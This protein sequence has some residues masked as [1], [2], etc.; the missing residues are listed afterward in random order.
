MPKLRSTPSEVL[1]LSERDEALLASLA[2]HQFLTFSQ[3][4]RLHFHARSETPARRALWRLADQGLAGNV[5]E[6]TPYGRQTVWY[7]TAAGEVASGLRLPGTRRRRTAHLGLG[8]LAHTLSVNEFCIGLVEE[9]RQRRDHFSWSSW[10]NEVAH[11]IPKQGLLIPDAA[12]FFEFRDGGGALRF[13]EMDTGSMALDRV[14]VKCGRYRVLH[15]SET[16]RGT[17]PIFPKVATV[18]GG[19]NQENRLRYLLDQ[20]SRVTGYESRGPKFLFAKEKDLKE[21]GPLSRVWWWSRLYA[22][23]ERLNFFED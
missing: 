18:L 11:R 15:D 3:V 5:F 17:Y 13:L 22:E 2:S 20:A 21:H 8:K 14:G 9:A 1:T 23:P 16:W 19:R 4:R 6:W 12:L 7:V 10:R